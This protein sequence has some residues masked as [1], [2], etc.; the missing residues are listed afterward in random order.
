MDFP[1][2]VLRFSSISLKGTV[3]CDGTGD[4]FFFREHLLFFLK[5]TQKSRQ[6][7]KNGFEWLFIDPEALHNAA[8]Q[9]RSQSFMMESLRVMPKQLQ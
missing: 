8:S 9:K 3:I 2:S 4:L 1:V 6:S 5:G 7:Q